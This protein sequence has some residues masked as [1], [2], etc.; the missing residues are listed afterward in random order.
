MN[1]TDLDRALASLCLDHRLLAPARALALIEQNNGDP[2]RLAE[3]I[4][5]E[6]SELALLQAIAT[7]MGYVFVDLYGARVGLRNDNELLSR[8]DRELLRNYS[9]LPL[10]DESGNVIVAVVNPSDLDLRAYLTERYPDMRMVLAS[11]S[12]IQAKLAMIGTTQIELGEEEQ[13][14]PPPPV[15]STAVAA[16]PRNPLVG[17]VDNVLETAVAQGA[18]DIHFN[19]NADGSLLLRFRIDGVL[20][21]QPT[22]TR[23]RENEIIGIVMN[24]SNMDTANQRDAQDGSFSFNAAGRKIDVRA[25]MLPQMNGTSIVLRLLDSINVNRNLTDMGFAPSHLAALTMA[26][27]S[28]QGTVIVCGPTGSGKTTTLYALLREVASVEKN[29][30]TI[31]DPVEYRLNLVNQTAVNTIGDRELDFDDVLRASLRMD[32]DVILVGEIRDQLTAKTAMDAA[33]TGHLVLTTVHARNTVSIYTRLAEMAVPAYLTAEAMSLGVSQRLVR[34]L[35]DCAQLGPTTETDRALF[36]QLGATAPDQLLH[37]IGCEACN[38]SGYR[39]RVAV[40]E[41]LVPTPAFRALVIARASHDELEA[42]ARADG[43][44]PMIDDGLRLVREQLTTIDEI[45]RAVT[46]GI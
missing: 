28:S 20:R 15:A 18:S 34:R 21:A 43:M 44:V 2:R 17:W 11:R 29:I 5:S 12:Q 14:A 45:A 31:E 39:G 24:K 13:I 30:I 46:A 26:A 41:V 7:E 10:L 23:G 40:V 37:P 1:V 16:T 38:R 32:P 36:R 25:G 33:I 35:H 4:A 22:P 9:A 19:L 3:A 6:V 27:K 42:Q 8:A